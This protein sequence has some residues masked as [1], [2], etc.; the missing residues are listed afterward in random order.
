MINQEK[1]WELKKTNPDKFISV[2]HDLYAIIIALAF[3][4]SP[5]MPT[6][7]QQI[8]KLLGLSVSKLWPEK[9]KE[10]DTISTLTKQIDT[11]IKPEP[12]FT[13]IVSSEEQS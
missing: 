12:L 10:V 6:S 1:L 3:L 11:S 2:L 8:F 13:K 7:S 4:I 9:D 5:L